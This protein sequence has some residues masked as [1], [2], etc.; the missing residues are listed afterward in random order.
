MT[1]PIDDEVVSHNPLDVDQQG[2]ENIWLG[3]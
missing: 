3:R 2:Q 1:L